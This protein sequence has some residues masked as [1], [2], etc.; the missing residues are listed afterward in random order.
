MVIV[1]LE[2]TEYRIDENAHGPVEVCAIMSVQCVP[3]NFQ[4]LLS[5]FDGTAG[6]S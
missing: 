1:N 4:V 5:T 3:F 6:M 2:E